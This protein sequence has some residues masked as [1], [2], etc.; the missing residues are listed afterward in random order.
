MPE[1]EQSTWRR[2]QQGDRQSLEAIYHQHYAALIN[3]T[4]RF[5]SDL[6]LIEECIQDLFVKLWINRL[7]LKTPPSVRNYLLKS[8]RHILYNRFS[9][10]GRL[11]F[12]GAGEDRM[13]FELGLHITGG[14]QR[15]DDDE[16]SDR[17]AYL[18]RQLTPRQRE[19][20][21][22]IF[23]EDMSYEEA[24][25]LLGISTKSMYKLVYRS[26]DQLKKHAGPSL[27]P[28]LLYLLYLSAGPAN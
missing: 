18:L 28:A 12:I 1:N 19:A 21:Y 11:T 15:Y 27:G 25:S 13:P 5:T 17:V 20:I 3:Y 10:S 4:R 7:N 22:L 16:V 14:S 8:I 2:F 6:L 24:A 23:F 9:S 26:I